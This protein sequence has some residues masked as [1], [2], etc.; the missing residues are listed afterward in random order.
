MVIESNVS[1]VKKDNGFKRIEQKCHQLSYMVK[2]Q[3]VEKDVAVKLIS[4]EE[5]LNQ[6]SALRGKVYSQK[7]ESIISCYQDN[8]LLEK[9]DFDAYIFAFFFNGKMVASQR[10]RMF[11]FEVCHYIEEQK[12]TSF[13]GEDFKDNYI[14][15][16]RLIVDNVHG[17][18]SRMV[19]HCLAV[20]SSTSILIPMGIQRAITYTKPRMKR[21]NI[22]FSNENIDF[23]IEE[24]AQTYHLFK[25]NIIDDIIKRLKLEI[26]NP[27]EVIDFI[28]QRIDNQQSI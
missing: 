10:I 5:E 6:L 26:T 8:L 11:P 2:N 22:N 3:F 13:L 19:A 4:S 20:I 27:Q 12:L 25:V 17:L 16:S 23:F 15:Y 14:E 9:D 21:K 24:R 28:S 1:T 7:N 18:S